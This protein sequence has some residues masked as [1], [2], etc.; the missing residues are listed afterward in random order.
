MP[1]TGTAAH[2]FIRRA[3]WPKD[4]PV[5]DYMG[6]MMDADTRL[7][8][9][10]RQARLIC[11]S[12][13]DAP[14]LTLGFHA[15]ALPAAKLLPIKAASKT[16]SDETYKAVLDHCAARTPDMPQ[17]AGDII[18]RDE[19]TAWGRNDTVMGD[20]Q[21]HHFITVSFF[22]PNSPRGYSS[23]AWPQLRDCL[24]SSLG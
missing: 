1:Y 3:F 15:V 13:H 21:H 12:V 7:A 6:H 22:L 5:T 20:G 23:T 18:R 4:Q 14:A 11:Y 8:R 19:L 9:G 2:L 17:R 10:G 24:S 16:A